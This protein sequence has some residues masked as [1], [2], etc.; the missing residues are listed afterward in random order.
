MNRRIVTSVASLAALAVL[1]SACTAGSSGGSGAGKSS[2]ASAGSG[3]A[4]GSTAA[5]P[6]TY[7]PN[8]PV[9]SW[10]GGKKVKIGLA[11][12]FGGNAW[13]TISLNVIKQAAAKCAAADKNILY[14][15]AGGDQQKAISD[16]NS[17][18]AQG[19]NVLI[20]YADFGP[21][22]LPAIRAAKKAGVFVVPYDASVGGT[23]G[24]DFTATTIADAF[25]GG[26]QLA[27]WVGKNVPKGNVV[28]LGGI[29]GAPTSA[30]YMAGIKN[31]LKSY[32]GVKLLQTTPVVTNWTKVDAQKAVTGLIA[33]YP[34]IDAVIT[35]YGVTAVAAINAFTAA[36]KKVPAIASLA[37]D[38][39]LGC[40]WKAASTGAGK[41]P[42]FSIDSTNAMAALAL[43]QGMAAANGK[44]FHA[45]QL[46]QLPVFMN[47][48]DGKNPPCDKALPP[49]ADLSSPLSQATLAKILK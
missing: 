32:P 38:N 13:R 8:T 10:C 44:T 19:V 46:F 27:D 4:A 28:F 47:S 48:V 3:G 6:V 33:K 12:G 40:V 20:V 43:Q 39:E 49:D 2:G 26:Q 29:P 24:A 31:K 1:A 34:N 14:T 36:G 30:Q 15:N 17:L 37:T 23:P 18:V 42:I 5:V 16:I 25:A 7:D 11:D 45:N 22:E 35:D 41:F 21:A 9:S